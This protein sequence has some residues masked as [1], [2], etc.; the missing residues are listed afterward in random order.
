M[1]KTYTNLE[2]TKHEKYR[3]DG[4]IRAEK[5][6]FVEEQSRAGRKGKN[7]KGAD[8]FSISRGIITFSNFQTIEMN[9]GRTTLNESYRG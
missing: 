2:S 7:E 5:Q 8:F 3:W 6:L 9:K 4:K 1:V